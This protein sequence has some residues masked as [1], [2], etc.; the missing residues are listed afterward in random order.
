MKKKLIWVHKSPSFKEAEEF[1]K[2]YYTKMS[3]EERLDIMQQLRE[4][5]FKIKGSKNECAK[6]LRRSIK[7]IQQ[8]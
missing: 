3:P 6:R 7:I 5:Y 8:T 4:Q 2:S 1:E